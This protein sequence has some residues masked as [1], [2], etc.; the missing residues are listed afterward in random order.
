MPT[1]YSVNFTALEI[2]NG[3]LGEPSVIRQST[4]IWRLDGSDIDADKEIDAMI[5][6]GVLP[7]MNSG[8]P[9]PTGATWEQYARLREMSY[10]PDKSKKVVYFD[11]TYSTLYYLNPQLTPASYHLPGKV[12]YSSKVRATKI[13]R[14]AWT[15]SPATASGTGDKSADIGGT[16]VDGGDMGITVELGQVLVRITTTYDASAAAM[17]TIYANR[18]AILNYRNSVAFGGFP[19]KS[20]EC[21]SITCN[22]VGGGFEFYEIKYELVYDPWYH[23]AQTP[24]IGEDGRPIANNSYQPATV[25]WTRS[26]ID[27]IDFNPYIFGDGTT[28]DTVERDLVLK[29]WWS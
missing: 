28:T 3:E 15:L 25:R 7:V 5:A 19:A 2:R 26:S 14:N 22:K 23:F 4:A 12:E 11:L 29:G 24:D 18:F 9:A 16:T 21:R 10:R 27:A 1:T 20:L 8:Y 17:N 6:D 13:Y